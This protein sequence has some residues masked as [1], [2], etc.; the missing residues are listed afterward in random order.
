MSIEIWQ[1]PTSG[2][3]DD[4]RRLLQGRGFSAGRNLFWP[5]PPGTLHFFWETPEDF[6]STSGVDAAVF[7]L[8]EEGRRVWKS[9]HSWA[10]RTRTS[11]WATS[12]DKGFHNATVREIR[13]AF[14]GKFFNDDVGWNRYIAIERHPST[15]ASRG[16]YAVLSRTIEELK[17][18]E[19]A[20]PPDVVHQLYT[21]R[22]IVTDKTDDSGILA[23]TKQFDPSRVVLNA[24][25]PFLLAC[26][27]Y[28][29]RESF[30]ILLRYSDP[31][32]QKL[33]NLGRKVSFTEAI[34]ISRGGM[35]VE[36]IGAD[37]YSFQSL[38]GVGRAFSDVLGIDVLR[39]LRNRRKVGTKKP[40]LRRFLSDLIKRRHGLVHRLTVDRQLDRATFLRDLEGV[41]LLLKSAAAEIERALG[42]PLGPG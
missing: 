11:M 25:L 17:S 16:V 4:F 27:E 24:L 37:A 10:V 20:L 41:R 5:G 31:G 3:K 21:P 33:E 2:T 28:F 19:Y 40:I 15:P 6:K 14:G 42:V 7:P 38:D 1:F 18:L 26:I 9:P 29:F 34:A 13:R 35:T 23:F 32:R 39:S 30:I 36:E 12:F 22:G 8:D